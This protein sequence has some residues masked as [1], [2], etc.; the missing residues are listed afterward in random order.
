M[1]RVYAAERSWGC[2]SQR[3][4]A[5]PTAALKCSCARGAAAP[6]ACPLLRPCDCHGPTAGE[7]S[8]DAME[9]EVVV[10]MERM[11]MLRSTVFHTLQNR[12]P[13]FGQLE[14]RGFS[15]QL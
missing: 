15:V 14:V 4:R 7:G 2:V 9:V 13:F 3:R 11:E 6:A 12:S 10:D 1:L 8:S 5:M